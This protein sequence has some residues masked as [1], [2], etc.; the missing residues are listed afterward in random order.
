MLDDDHDDTN[1]LRLKSICG[2]TLVIVFII[3]MLDILSDKT[4]LKNI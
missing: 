3:T 2:I 4:F 1:Y